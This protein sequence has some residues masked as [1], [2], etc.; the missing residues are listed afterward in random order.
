MTEDEIKRH[1]EWYRY[2]FG[3]SRLTPERKCKR[4][5]LTEESKY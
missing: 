3:Q 5:A 2:Y 4:G 1:E